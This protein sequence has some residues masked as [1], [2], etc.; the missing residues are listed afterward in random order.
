M[1]VMLMT[2]DISLFFTNYT[3]MIQVTRDAARRAAI[4]EV[5]DLAELEA[6]TRTR[7]SNRGFAFASVSGNTV[8]VTTQRAVA[9][10]VISAIFVNLW[11]GEK[12]G[13]TLTLNTQNAN[14]ITT[15][16]SMRL[17]PGVRL[18]RS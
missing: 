18:T 8:T 9:D 13:D 7:L 12:S 5:T 1:A 3:Q 17:E 4:G 15:Q 14:Y 10:V 11:G 16:S 2:V 6:R